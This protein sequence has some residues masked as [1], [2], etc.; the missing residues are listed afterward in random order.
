MVSVKE[1][2]AEFNKKERPKSRPRRGETGKAFH[3]RDPEGSKKYWEWNEEWKEIKT[4][5]DKEFVNGFNDVISPLTKLNPIADKVREVAHGFIDDSLVYRRV[6]YP[7][8]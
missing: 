4:Q 5:G 6:P 2:W 1:R 7:W 3:E 8:G